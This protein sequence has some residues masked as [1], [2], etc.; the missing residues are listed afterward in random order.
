MTRLNRSIVVLLIICST[1]T[2][3]S[4]IQIGK[5][6]NSNE[7][8]YDTIIAEFFLFSLYSSRPDMFVLPYDGEY[9]SPDTD[10]RIIFSRP[11]NKT[12]DWSV[13]VDSVVYDNSSPEIFWDS[14]SLG[15]YSFPELI[16]HPTNPLMRGKTITVIA[17]GFIG[18]SKIVSSFTIN[19]SYQNISITPSDY[20]TQ[21]APDANV[22]LTFSESAD[23]SSDWNV[24]IDGVAYDKS[25][26][27]ILWNEQHTVLTIN[28]AGYFQRNKTIRLSVFG[29]TASYDGSPFNSATRR[30]TIMSRPY[31]TT[32]PANAEKAVYIN[33]NIVIT[34]SEPMVPDDGWSVIA[35]GVTYTKDSPGIVW[36]DEK[37]LII[38]KTTNFPLL[39]KITAV[40]QGFHAAMDN[41]LFSGPLNVTFMTGLNIESIPMNNAI[42]GGTRFSSVVDSHDK[43]YV[44]YYDRNLQYP[45]YITNKSGNWEVYP[46]DTREN[47]DSH[48]PLAI[49]SGDSLLAVYTDEWCNNATFA[50][51]ENGSWSLQNFDPVDHRGTAASITADSLNAVHISYWSI[52][53]SDDL[54]YATNQG[55]AWTI[56]TI[57]PGLSYSAH[58]SSIAVDSNNKIHVSYYGN[59]NLRY[60]TNS[61]GS[62]KTYIVDST[63]FSGYNSVIAIDSNDA[64]HIAYYDTSDFHNWCIRYVTNKSGAWQRYQVDK[65]FYTNYDISI[66]IDSH[67]AVYISYIDF[68]QSDYKS[69]VKLASTKSGAWSIYY[70]DS[71]EWMGYNVSM[72]IDSNDYLHIFYECGWENPILRHA[73][74][75]P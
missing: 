47:L 45:V 3:L 14:L 53:P 51:N 6:N 50:K 20:A 35:A 67:N 4:C 15:D 61:D 62:W 27:E 21:I 60:A 59:D 28:P 39:S 46:I 9:V 57:D 55:G 22:V 38:N 31:A 65:V 19:T 26:P 8:K 44:S 71:D 33:R 32:S 66:C 2:L 68:I 72:K 12:A 7:K 36:N 24:T 23:E 30:F 58:N 75:A 40:L 48:I 1:A 64:V 16:I 5:G 18:F 74:N 25:S 52:Y 70:A 17:D 63:R 54:F 69:Y 29:F 37:T 10:I 56:H 41:A 34:F 43:L 13:T 11:V 49:D 73:T 42:S